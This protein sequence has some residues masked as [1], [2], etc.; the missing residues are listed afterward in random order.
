MSCR[1]HKKYK[2]LVYRSA[3]KNA[4]ASG[5]SLGAPPILK[6]RANLLDSEA[7][8]WNNSGQVLSGGYRFFERHGLESEDR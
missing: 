8:A 2:K 4:A 5:K 7:C 6:M 3:K 1:K